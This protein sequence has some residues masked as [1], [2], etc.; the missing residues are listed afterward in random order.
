MKNKDTSAWTQPKDPLHK[1]LMTLD[2]KSNIYGEDLFNQK[3]EPIEDKFLSAFDWD[4]IKSY[5]DNTF[6]DMM[7]SE[8]RDGQ[9]QDFM[10]NQQQIGRHLRMK[11]I[12]WLYEVIT[13][14]RIT[15]RSIMF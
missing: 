1:K 14:F 6:E 13:K 4:F 5:G 8:M 15:D 10:S 11:V 3:F 12:D 7:K 9:S 2:D